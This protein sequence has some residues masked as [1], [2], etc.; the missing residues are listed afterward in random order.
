MFSS[1]RRLLKRSKDRELP[2]EAEKD[3][4]AEGNVNN[5]LENNAASA[6]MA[7][8]LLNR[9]HPGLAADISRLRRQHRELQ[10]RFK[11]LPPGRPHIRQTKVIAALT[12]MTEGSRSAAQPGRNL[13]RPLTSIDPSWL[14]ARSAHRIKTTKIP[15]YR[16]SSANGVQKSASLEAETSLDTWHHHTRKAALPTAAAAMPPSEKNENAAAAPFKKAASAHRMRR[17]REW[18]L[19]H[20]QD[21]AGAEGG[22]EQDFVEAALAKIQQGTINTN[23]AAASN[24]AKGTSSTL[25]DKAWSIMAGL[26]LETSDK[27]RA[28]IAVAE[29]TAAGGGGGATSKAT[30]TVDALDAGKETHSGDRRKTEPLNTNQPVGRKPSRSDGERQKEVGEG[31]GA[32]T[33]WQRSS[34]VGRPRTR[35]GIQ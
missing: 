9:P 10:R 16:D 17:L 15:S 1:F 4:Y 25:K 2:Q 19:T 34:L 28:A 29:N 11:Q 31:R 5:K 3:S 13:G 24:E 7:L 32:G 18:S 27:K 22:G 6:Y 8:T 12:K 35:V 21:V 23:S 14:A 26:S 20:G 30:A 33:K